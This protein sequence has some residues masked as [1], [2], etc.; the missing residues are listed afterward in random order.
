MQ[1]PNLEAIYTSKLPA[2]FK[3]LGALNPFLSICRT[4]S[5]TPAP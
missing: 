3:Q 4:G 1:A 2:K 5:S